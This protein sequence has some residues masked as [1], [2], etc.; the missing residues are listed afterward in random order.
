RQVFDA[1]G[2]EAVVLEFSDEQLAYVDQGR[3]VWSRVVI[4]A[5][6]YP[7]HD[8]DLFTVG[9]PNILAVR[10]DIDDDVVY[11]ITKTIFEN[12][13]YLHGLHD[14]TSQI[15][16]DTA[17]NC[18]PLPIHEG[19]LRY[20]AEM[21]VELPAPPVEVDPNLLSRFDDTR[22]AR[23]EAN[24]GVLSMFT[25]A[26]GD[27][28][29]R[30][31]A[32]LASALNVGED[33]FRVLP[34]FGGGSSQN[35]TDLL[36]LKGVDSALMRTDVIAYATEH[37]VYPSLEEQIAYITEMFPEEVHLLVREDVN[38]VRELE[39][40]NVNIGAPGSGSEITASV[41][42]SQ[43]DI[44]VQAT[45]FEPYAALDK[46]K[47]GEISGAFFVGGKPMPLL[48]EI[49]EGS[50]LRLLSIPFVQYGNS[51]RS[52]EITPGDYPNLLAKTPDESISTVAV[53]TAL[54]TYAW[55]PDSSRYETLA[56]FSNAFFE[57]LSELHQEGR[58]PKWR[59]VD[60]TSEIFGL[61]RFEPARIWVESNFDTAQRI[62]L[63]GRY[64][65]DQPSSNAAS[66]SSTDPITAPVLLDQ[67]EPLRSQTEPSPTAADDNGS[68]E[69]VERIMD[70]TTSERG[71]ASSVPANG[72]NDQGRQVNSTATSFTR[73]NRRTS[74][75]GS[76]ETLP[77]ATVNSPTF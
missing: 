28:S 38:N 64:L 4:P 42:L 23:E 54:F 37:Q 51:Y 45:E 22:Q 12:L 77:T 74:S 25:G 71:A 75:N 60:P 15:S 72:A 21:N 19:A 59:Q 50:G 18:L 69:A 76:I 20:F 62:A 52:A 5:E 9:T 7:G 10:A 16:L 32:E 70:S 61:K 36:Y 34:T 35:L 8:R 39:G 3:R 65:N 27:T 11:Q 53:R 68:L 55:R 26:D 46:L 2:D 44:P 31:A 1:L 49:D 14:L 33:G 48:K 43:L 24:R 63:E 40:Q 67:Q 13:D 29:A 56:R 17:I 57:H 73:D 47:S 6:T 30:A 66:L 58:H 41:I